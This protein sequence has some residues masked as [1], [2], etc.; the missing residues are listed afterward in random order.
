MVYGCVVE[1][2]FVSRPNRITHQEFVVTWARATE[3][4]VRVS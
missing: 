3:S 1:W 4:G 2:R